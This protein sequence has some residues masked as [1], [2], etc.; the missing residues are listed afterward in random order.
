MKHDA[1]A[2]EGDGALVE[3]AGYNRASTTIATRRQ[4]M[5]RAGVPPRLADLVAQLAFGDARQ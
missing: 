4:A 1:T 5:R 2:P 3:L